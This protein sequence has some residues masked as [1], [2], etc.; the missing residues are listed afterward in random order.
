M[1]I[2]P[3][4]VNLLVSYAANVGAD[5]TRWVAGK[6]RRRGQETPAETLASLNLSVQAQLTSN[7]VADTD[8]EKI[9]SFLLETPILGY[10]FM[11][12]NAAQ[13][14][15]YAGLPEEEI[16]A[17]LML[18]AGLSEEAAPAAADIV[19]AVLGAR[20]SRAPN[21]RRAARGSRSRPL[22]GI[23]L[24]G[25][26]EAKRR[27]LAGIGSPSPVEIL[28]YSVA[29][30]R[31]MH[32]KYSR[33]QLQHLDNGTEQRLEDLYVEPDLRVREFDS[34]NE[35]TIK[36]AQ[37]LTSYGRTV[38]Q[39]AAGSGKSTT[40]RRLA[41]DVATGVNTDLVPIVVELRKYSAQQTLAP[42]IFLDH[43]KQSTTQLMQQA[44]PAHWLEYLLVTGRAVLFF[45]GLDE[46]LNAGTRAEVRDAVL[47][48]AQLFPATS[49]FVTSRYTGYDLAPF[50][51]TEWV[52]VGVED[53]RED[54]VREYAT[55]WFSLKS[56]AEDAA[57]RASSFVEESRRYAA[58]LRV[59][60]L[61]LSL[62]CSIYYARG[63]IPRTLHALYERC[64]DM[65][66]QQWNTM[67]GIDDHRA[68]DK[69]VRPV[70]YQVAHSVLSND[71]YMSFGIPHEELVTEIR[72][73]FISN[74]A[75][76]PEDASRRAREAVQLWAGRAWIITTVMTDEAGRLRYGFVHQSFL[77]YFAAVYEVRRVDTPAELYA[78]LR[79]RLIELN[80]W[81]VTQIA[82]SVIDAWRDHGGQRFLAA[83]LDDAQEA[84]DLDAFALLRLGISLVSVVP[85]PPDQQSVLA[86]T[87]VRF[88]AR[89]ILLP[90]G[91]SAVYAANEENSYRT[92][93]AAD[94]DIEEDEPSS[95]PTVELGVRESVTLPT[96]RSGVVAKDL[97]ALAK[98]NSS[99]ATL[100][101]AATIRCIEDQ[102][103]E[104]VTAALLQIAILASEKVWT[105]PLTKRA[106]IALATHDRHWVVSWI[107]AQLHIIPL[108]DAVQVVPWHATLLVQELILTDEVDIYGPEPFGPILND[109]LDDDDSYRLLERIGASHSD[110]LARG[111]PL[112][113]VRRDLI[114]R[115]FVFREPP[116]DW[117][118]ARDPDSWSDAFLVSFAM[119]GRLA[120]IAW[121]NGHALGES[122]DQ[123]GR[124]IAIQIA[125]ASLG[126]GAVDEDELAAVTEPHRSAIRSILAGPG[127]TSD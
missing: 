65:I 46:V 32:R 62:L 117:R 9:A 109:C 15:D 18:E 56:V 91:D 75:P 88:V 103:D 16:A 77:E 44:P 94:F 104:V 42:Q 10:L 54:Q 24:F 111:I 41:A 23:Q 69:D 76:D 51:W 39:G 116:S 50:D 13:T 113:A 29:F 106:K 80:G 37:L 101:T 28:E 118:Q 115:N 64:A 70:L 55:R 89:S 122:L 119:I 5:A 48:F 121:K 20:P 45:D 81:T 126:W 14:G 112:P 79:S 86:D 107:A 114:E 124:P 22:S 63:D 60:P 92:R 71:E 108:E 2:D 105:N 97:S 73:A 102:K 47:A 58:D 21:G 98:D 96:T 33:I 27:M 25:A 78:N 110:R 123:S 26:Q 17:L 67:R 19:A 100:I 12:V 68:W 84:C 38:V 34:R 31:E 72:R 1:D 127:L 36:P 7:G 49:I 6:F 35:S 40:I 83:L 66:Y 43:I 8:A 82:V 61:M 99:A 87:G 85:I 53:L 120:S 3:T 52:H 57:T 59:N 30:R 125:A 93:G 90:A 74:G 95:V 4:L 11:L